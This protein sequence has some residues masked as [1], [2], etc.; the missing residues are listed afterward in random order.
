M[1]IYIAGSFGERFRLRGY[2]GMLEKRGYTVTASWLDIP[3]RDL[4]LGSEERMR[5]DAALDF[6]EVGQSDLVIV[7]TLVP[8]STGGSDAEMGFAFGRMKRVWV[9]GPVRNLYHTIA[10]RRFHNWDE[11]FAALLFVALRGERAHT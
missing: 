6:S 5:V 2:R 8:S 9:V 3:A 1:N 4:A 7:D 10:R 11:M